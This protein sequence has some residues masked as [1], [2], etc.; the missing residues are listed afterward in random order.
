MLFLVPLVPILIIIGIV[1]L[2]M[3]RKNPDGSPAGRGLSLKHFTFLMSAFIALCVVVGNVLSLLFTI[4]NTKFPATVNYYYSYSD[5]SSFSMPMAILIVSLPLLI[6]FRWLLAK[7]YM[8]DPEARSS[9]LARGLNYLTLFLAGG[10]I[11]GDLITVLYY[12]IDGRDMSTAFILKVLVL[13][14]VAGSVFVY[15]VSELRNKLTSQ[16]RMIWRWVAIILVA[17]SIVLGFV[18]LGSPRS[19]RLYKYDEQR[20]TDLMDINNS[21]IAY[22]QTHS[23]LP[24]SLADL[25]SGNDYYVVPKDPETGNQYEYI[26]VGQS[27]KAYQVCAEFNKA[28]KNTGS[29]PYGENWTHPAGHHCFDRVIDINMYPKPVR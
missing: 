24:G 17:G 28:S 19:Q 26:L 23:G 7:E 22:F 15:F 21:V 1:A 14:L 8:A 13:L 27:A 12:F 2:V 4:I 9:V 3:N 18:V 6:L 5:T 20:V 29:Y 11:V 25:N 10:T 16:S